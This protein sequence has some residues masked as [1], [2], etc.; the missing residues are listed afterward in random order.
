MHHAKEFA[1]C[2]IDLEMHRVS[3]RHDHYYHQMVW[4]LLA[5]NANGG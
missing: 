5:G 4:I 3:M 2:V 1:A